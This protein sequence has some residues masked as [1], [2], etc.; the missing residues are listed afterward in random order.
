MWIKKCDYLSPSI[1]L[2]YNNESIH[3]SI[4]S[5]LLSIFAYGFSLIFG[6]YLT[7]DFFT[8][9][10][11]NA[12]YFH[13]YIDD[14]GEFPINSSVIFS[15]I[16]LLDASTNKQE[17]IY[18]DQLR[19]IGLEETIEV[20]HRDT[21]LTKYNHWIYGSCN[22]NEDAYD[23]KN[24][25]SDEDKKNFENSACIK[26]YY[27]KNDEK[28]Y[29]VS[30]ENFRWPNLKHGCSHPERTFY[31]IT[32]EKCKNDSL[33][34]LDGKICKSEEEI[35]K[36]IKTRSIQ[37][38]VVDQYVDVL[39][40]KKPL[41]KYFYSIS[42]GLFEDTYTVNHLNFNPALLITHSGIFVQ[43]D[44]Q[45]KSYIFDQN[46]KIESQTADTGIYVAFYFWM[47]NRMQYYDRSYKTFLDLLSDMGGFGSIIVTFAEIINILISNYTILIDT[48][49]LVFD[50]LKIVKEENDKKKYPLNN[51]EPTIYKNLEKD[52]DPYYNPPIKK[53]I[54][55]LNFENENKNFKRYSQKEI[56]S[57]PKKY[58][59]RTVRKDKTNDRLNRGGRFSVIN[60]KKSSFKN[61]NKVNNNSVSSRGLP[62]I[63]IKNLKIKEIIDDS[64]MNDIL[65][66]NNLYKKKE[67]QKEKIT[68]KSRNEKKIENKNI[69]NMIKYK[70]FYFHEYL[71]NF[72]CCGKVKKNI[73][74]FEDFRNK[75]ISEEMITQNHFNIYKLKKLIEYIMKKN[76][77]SN[78]LF[79]LQ[80]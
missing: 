80:S 46:E 2:S 65:G 31:G 68:D 50:C 43:D 47:Q 70:K 64:A 36:S 7:S 55:I 78:D 1:T 51:L 42:N 48:Q 33:S 9:K 40:Y 5:G 54:K 29:N 38:K 53:K 76:E 75:V 41:T 71:H 57:I 58:S 26:K 59:T 19:I 69:K 60:P 39:N 22:I 35:S 67:K 34:K 62:S 30:S 24:L 44:S 4:F 74:Y 63:L 37:M 23:V 56:E 45:E 32:V 17:I 73:S 61:T 15:Y 14:A 8:H 79:P 28:Y 3:P 21:N 10:N 49:E 72:I 25:I 12:Y 66:S 13:R 16:Q 52:L 11:P 27:N 6:L 20:Y 77:D 18:Y